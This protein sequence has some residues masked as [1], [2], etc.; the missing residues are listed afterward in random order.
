MPPTFLLLLLMLELV[1][2]APFIAVITIVQIC[3]KKWRQRGIR[4]LQWSSLGAL[5]LCAMWLAFLV[6]FAS[7]QSADWETALFVVGA[8]F[9]GGAC[10]QWVHSGYA[11]QA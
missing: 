10:A 9:S 6:L 3:V 2:L 5:M 7:V 1:F 8:G 11:K 4:S